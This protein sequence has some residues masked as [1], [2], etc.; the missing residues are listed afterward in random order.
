MAK[1]FNRTGR[2]KN[3]TVARPK[4]DSL[5]A[6][7]NVIANVITFARSRAFFSR[8]TV[9]FMLFPSPLFFLVDHFYHHIYLIC[10]KDRSDSFGP[11]DVFHRASDD[12]PLHF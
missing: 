9:C 1:Y 6:I 12:A 11:N 10:G 8:G 5:S 3:K 2:N 7:S 4:D